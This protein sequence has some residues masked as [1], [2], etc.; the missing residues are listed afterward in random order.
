MIFFV[1]Q[2]FRLYL[3]FMCLVSL[4]G[5]AVIFQA[6]I[7]CLPKVCL[8]CQTTGLTRCVSYLLL[9]TCCRNESKLCL[10]RE[11]S[12]LSVNTVLAKRLQSFWQA[13]SACFFQSQTE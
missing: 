5:R 4:A 10:A 9:K 2:Q 13:R 6:N 8:K 1:L 3:S 12:M 11:V 7:T